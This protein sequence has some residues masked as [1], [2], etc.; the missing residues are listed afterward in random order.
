[1]PSLRDPRKGDGSTPRHFEN[2]KMWLLRQQMASVR[3][4]ECTPL[5]GNAENSAEI[6][7]LD[8]RSKVWCCTRPKTSGNQVEA[9]P[10]SGNLS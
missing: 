2:V 3:M 5:K 7:F 10:I 6:V 8:V 9:R 1:M 4:D